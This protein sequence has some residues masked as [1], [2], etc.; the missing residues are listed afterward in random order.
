MPAAEAKDGVD[1][2][3]VRVYRCAPDST[4]DPAGTVECVGCGERQGFVGRDALWGR[5]FL[6]GAHAHERAPADSG[7]G[8]E[9]SS[10]I[11]AKR[12]IR[13]KG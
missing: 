11:V 12:D 10:G 5:L 4:D 13:R 2:F 7:T 3:I 1:T 9:R 8:S 6:A